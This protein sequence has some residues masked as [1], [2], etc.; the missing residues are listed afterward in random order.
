[1]QVQYGMRIANRWSEPITLRSI[2]VTSMGMGGPYILKRDTYFF[3]KKKPAEAAAEEEATA[4]APPVA[5]PVVPR[6]DERR[7]QRRRELP[8]VHDPG[9]QNRLHLAGEP[10]ASTAPSRTARTSARMT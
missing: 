10:F 8:P 1:M 4:G 2:E 7:E 5:R 6:D 9:R 3:G